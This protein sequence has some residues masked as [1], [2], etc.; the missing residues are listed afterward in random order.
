MRY[1][2]CM[3]LIVLFLN[4]CRNKEKYYTLPFPGKPEVPSSIKKEHTYLLDRLHKLTSLQDSTG[5]AA[6]KL[7]D[8][9]EHHFQE[10]EDY[11][12]APLGVLPLLASGKIPEESKKIILL[13]EKF[14]S[15]S[16]QMIA[17]HQLIKVYLD[18]L[19]L[20]AR[21]ENHPEIS[22]FE[23]ELHKHAAIEEEVLFPAAIL[24]G[25]YLKQ[26]SPAD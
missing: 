22:G 14:K 7:N 9:M 16:A 20:A 24:I 12:L 8:L 17:E 18:E 3:L 2:P 23:Q 6:I 21:K 11:V 26:N 4:Q 1:L 5:S 13:T 25:L 15:N 19:M 10:E